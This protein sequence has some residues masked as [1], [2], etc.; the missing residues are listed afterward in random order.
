VLIV[1]AAMGG[2]HLE[3]SREVARRLGARGHQV[4]IVDLTELMPAGA[5]SALRAVYPW[6]VNRAPWLY[7]LVYRYFFLARQ[8]A[9]SRVGIPVRLALPG[10][11]RHIAR[12]RPDIAV[13]TY[14]LAALALGRLRQQGSLGC[15]AVTF[16]TTFSVH[17]LWLHPST[18]A[19]LCISDDA[20]QEVRRR[21]GSA[22][23]LVCG[24]V[25]RAGFSE[26]AGTRRAGVR[27]E[28]GV[29]AGQQL[30]LVVGGSLGLGTVREAV[31]A[32]ARS[33]S[34]VPVVV[35][36]R[37]EALRAELAAIPG[38]VTL[39]WVSDMAALM[40]AADVLVE[41]AGGLTAKEALR[42]ELPVVTFRP[43]TGHGRH[44]ANALARLGLTDLVDGEVGLRAALTKLSGNTAPR[45]D[46][47]RRGRELFVGDAAGAVTA[48]IRRDSGLARHGGG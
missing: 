44:D 6:L 41:N 24:P 43:I 18:D 19:Y 13:S 12:F 45:A 2:G 29:T 36:G 25:V 7:E 3:V 31:A 14:H 42:M 48:L 22:D 46:R 32:I 39:G 10:L 40:G 35:C 33:P 28:L 17:E 38:T 16:I 30:A 23:V 47:V 1:T 26:Q 8:T 5:G 34:W 15:P 20:A 9:G 27:Q 37:D 4:E 11:R 21:D